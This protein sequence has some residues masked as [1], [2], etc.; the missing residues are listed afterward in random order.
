MSYSKVLN[1]DGHVPPMPDMGGAEVG[2][3]KVWSTNTKRTASAKMV[4]DIKGLKTTLDMSWSKMKQEDL[5]PIDEIASNESKPFFPVTYVDQRGRERTKI[6]YADSMV[7][8]RDVYRNGTIW[9]SDVT[10][11]L[12]EQ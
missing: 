2:V 12:V 5:T 7:Y 9:Y 6:F 1:I 10:L 8:K 4:G 11:N 3:Q